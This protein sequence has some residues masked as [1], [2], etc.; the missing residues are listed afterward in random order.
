MTLNK[1]FIIK[2]LNEQLKVETND[3]RINAYLR[4]IKNIRNYDKPLNDFKDL[5]NIKG[6]GPFFKKKIN[7]FYEEGEDDYKNLIIEKLSKLRDLELKNNETKKAK[8][9]ETVIEKLK[10]YDKPINKIE[11]ID[12]I[13]NSKIGVT[14]KRMIKEVIE[15]GDISYINKLTTALK[16]TKNKNKKINKIIEKIKLICEDYNKNISIIKKHNDANIADLINNPDIRN[17]IKELIKEELSSSSSSLKSSKS[18]H[19]HPLNKNF[20]K[21]VIIK[22]L[23]IIRDYEHYNNERYKIVAYNNAINN[24]IVYDKKIMDLNDI[25]NIE[26]IGKGIYEKIKELFLNGSISYIE[27]NINNDKDYQFKQILLNIYGV[28]PVNAKKIIDSGIKSLSELKKNLHLLNEKQKIGV[29]YY[30]DLNKKIPLDEFNKHIKIIENKLKKY[31]LTYDFVGSYRRGSD[32]MG[33]I[34]LLIMDDN[35]NKKFKLKD[36]IKELMDNDNNYVIEVLAI[37][38]NKFMG[39]VKIDNYPARHFDIL[40]APKKEYY[41][42]LLYFTGSKIFNVA[43][44]HYIKTKLNLSLSEHGF[45]DLDIKVDSEEDIFKFVKLHYIRP[46]NRND[47]IIL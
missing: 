33:D 4:V 8:A 46:I 39:V 11:D 32:K 31:K 21:D 7:E 34:D 5:D 9:Y 35:D 23:E 13:K 26:G 15:T 18:S 41:Y 29:K 30:E 37:G 19:S 40:I 12:N 3:T 20:N 27:N 38:K 2:K 24:I 6:I 16:K 25:A 36:F 44:R 17:D 10:D 42:S 45:K 14:I 1:S 43:M 47:F 28:G 22:N